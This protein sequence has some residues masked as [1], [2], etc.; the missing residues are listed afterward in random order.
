VRK[1]GGFA[2]SKFTLL[3]ESYSSVLKEKK[4]TKKKKKKTQKKKTK[5]KKTKENQNGA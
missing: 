3:A 5:K 4:S 1:K 2:S